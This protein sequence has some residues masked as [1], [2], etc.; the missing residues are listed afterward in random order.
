MAEHAVCS[1]SNMA[2]AKL[3]HAPKT[4][5]KNCI[6]A[7]L[8]HMG[9]PDYQQL[10]PANLFP[11]SIVTRNR[12]LDPKLQAGRDGNHLPGKVSK[13]DSL[14][15]FHW[16]SFDIEPLNWKF[17]PKYEAVFDDFVSTHQL[18]GVWIHQSIGKICVWKAASTFLQSLVDKMHTIIQ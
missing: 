8:W 4:T 14:I 16:G 12:T 9:L 10:C 6:D 7:S 5:W 18:I 17:S 15:F 11:G 2:R 3:L 1:V 13:W